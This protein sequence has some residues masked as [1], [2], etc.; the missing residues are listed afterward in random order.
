MKGTQWKTIFGHH[1]GGI[2]YG[3]KRTER[4]SPRPSLFL[5]WSYLSSA[6][7]VCDHP[8][9][10]ESILLQRLPNLSFTWNSAPTIDSVVSQLNPFRNRILDGLH[11]TF[12]GLSAAI[13]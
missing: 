3:G 10:F 13:E 9:C 5:E 8:D 11:G 1:I 4:N 12:G 2:H 7:L 6:N